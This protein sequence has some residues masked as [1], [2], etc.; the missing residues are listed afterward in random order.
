[1]YHA[2]GYNTILY[3]KA[4]M[5]CELVRARA[6]PWPG[7]GGGELKLGGSNQAPEVGGA[8]GGEKG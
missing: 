7:G 4:M 1:M 3:I 6:V 2:L 5:T 8:P